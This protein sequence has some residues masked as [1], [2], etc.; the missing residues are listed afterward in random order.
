MFFNVSP[1]V[2]CKHAWSLRYVGS[3]NVEL[4]GQNCNKGL[5]VVNKIKWSCNC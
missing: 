5:R 4:E 2:T 3:M 1:E